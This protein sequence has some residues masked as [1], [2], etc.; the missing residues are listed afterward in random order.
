LCTHSLSLAAFERLENR[1]QLELLSNPAPP[2]LHEPDNRFFQSSGV[3]TQRK[4]RWFVPVLTSPLPR[5]PTM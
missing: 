4:P 5:V 3:V 1:V 2:E